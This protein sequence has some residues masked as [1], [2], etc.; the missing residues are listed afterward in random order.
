MCILRVIR[1]ALASV[2]RQICATVDFPLMSEYLG[3][4][5]DLYES[6]V[7]NNSSRQ[8]PCL[9]IYL[10]VFNADITVK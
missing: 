10:E 2:Q 7:N 8:D 5:S 6:C 3:E 1:I 4:K 9:K